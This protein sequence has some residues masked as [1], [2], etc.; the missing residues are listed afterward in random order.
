MP[1]LQSWEGWKGLREDNVK[2]DRLVFCCDHVMENQREV[3]LITF[4]MGGDICY[5]CGEIDHDEQSFRG[6]SIQSLLIFA[7]TVRAV[8]KIRAGYQYERQGDGV[9]HEAPYIDD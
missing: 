7:P 1:R 3:K 8:G 5:L 2:P 9:W 4:T 6:V